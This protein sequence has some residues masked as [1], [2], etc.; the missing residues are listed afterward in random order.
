MRV[1]DYGRSYC[2]F[3]TKGRTNTA[4]LQ[5]EA[6]CELLD[7]ATGE[8]EEFFFFASCKAEHTHVPERLF[9]DPNYDFCGVFSAREFALFRTPASYDA[10]RNSMGPIEGTFESARQVIQWEDTR[11][12]KTPAQVV[13]ATLAGTP[14]VGRTEWEDPEVGFRAML[15]YPI[16]TMNVHPE[17]EQFQVDTGP[18]PFPDPARPG[19]RWIERL[20]P[21]FIAWNAP[22]RAEF[23]L[24]RP[25][26]VLRDGREVCRVLHYSEI[27]VFPV[28]NEVLAAEER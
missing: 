7:R 22:D 3:T 21:A 5:V 15:E 11:L 28:T 23:I 24:Q 16:K 4:R 13:E 27:R 17:S 9:Q 14:L 2:F 10:D 1:V 6:R 19:A 8:R 26:P 18:L 20:V 25:T 12:L